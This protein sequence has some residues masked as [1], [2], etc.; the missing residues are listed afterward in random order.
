MDHGVALTLTTLRATSQDLGL[1]RQIEHSRRQMLGGVDRPF[2]A[3]NLLPWGC[4][5]CI[6][7]ALGNDR[8]RP[9]AGLRKITLAPCASPCGFRRSDARQTETSLMPGASAVTASSLFQTARQSV[10]H[11]RQFSSGAGS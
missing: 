10:L 4:G 8:T 11:H 1:R 3:Q 9:G 7:P 6:S 2:L 5:C